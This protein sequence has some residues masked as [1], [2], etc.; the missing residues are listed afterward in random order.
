MADN[1]KIAAL[2]AA[3]A[4][5]PQGP[6]GPQ[7][8]AYEWMSRR[9]ADLVLPDRTAAAPPARPG[10]PKTR[11]PPEPTPPGAVPPGTLPP[12]ALPPPKS[13]LPPNPEPPV[14]GGP[15]DPGIPPGFEPPMYEPPVYEPPVYD[16]PVYGGP[17][18]APDPVEPIGQPVA[19]IEREPAYFN[20]DPYTFVPE[21]VVPPSEPVATPSEPVVSPAD[22]FDF[23]PIFDWSNFNN[24]QAPEVQIA[25]APQPEASIEPINPALFD[26]IAQEED[27]MLRLQKAYSDPYS[28]MAR[29]WFLP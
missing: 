18:Y 29:S 12:G 14:Y 4:P 25:A 23:T 27:P 9:G 7:A 5:A 1:A 20:P 10:S 6:S 17:V 24:I 19:P 3:T 8:L 13:V 15:V 28:R 26:M 22:Q 2:R 16:L 11:R 21:P